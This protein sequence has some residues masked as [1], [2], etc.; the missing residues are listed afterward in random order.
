MVAE[1]VT[2]WV[3]GTE[4]QLAVAKAVLKVVQKEIRLAAWTAFPKVAS[5]ATH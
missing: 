2:Q 5:T 4:D 1:K 3:V